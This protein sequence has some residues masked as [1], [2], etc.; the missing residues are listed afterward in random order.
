[1]RRVAVKRKKPER[2]QMGALKI[3]APAT[4]CGRYIRR[5]TKERAGHF[6]AQD[7]LKP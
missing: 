1:M 2:Q 6:E 7:K 5:K 3:K 4:V